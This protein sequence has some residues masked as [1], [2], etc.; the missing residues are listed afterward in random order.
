MGWVKES[1]SID[2]YVNKFRNQDTIKRYF[3]AF[4]FHP[5]KLSVLSFLQH[6]KQPTPLLDFTANFDVAVYFGTESLSEKSYSESESPIENYFSI[7]NIS[8]KNLELIDVK[9]VFGDLD[10]MKKE[11]LDNF[12][13]QDTNASLYLQHL[14]NMAALNTME[15]FL[16]DFE[17]Q[18]PA[19]N[20]QNSV[21]IL[22]QEGLFIHNSFGKDPLEIALKKFFIP[23]TQFVGH[24]ADDAEF[25]P[26]IKEMND[27]Y[28]EDLKSNSVIQK[29]L[30]KNIIDSYEIHK[31]LVPQIL[32][33][34]NINQSLIYPD[35]DKICK[36]VYD[37]SK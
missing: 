26:R 22:N 14:D 37:A 3:K 27:K 18:Y 7:F 23:A 32:D 17:N 8:Q 2:D 1:F 6:H 11:Y 9:R 25:D 13:K 20:V 12:G 5:S 21:R 16:V 30:E 15:V 10:K 24:E 33:S 36:E 28:R 29:K 31:S 19:F 34:L 35:F 4:D